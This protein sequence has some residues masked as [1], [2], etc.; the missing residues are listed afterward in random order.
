MQALLSNAVGG[1]SCR[2]EALPPCHR[3]DQWPP[4]P[5]SQT[6]NTSSAASVRVRIIFH[7]PPHGS[8]DF[9]TPTPMFQLHK[10]RVVCL[11]RV[12]CRSR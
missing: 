5:A 6:P 2:P 7:W 8:S 9:A 10:L 1:A 3:D 11:P 4:G 12:K